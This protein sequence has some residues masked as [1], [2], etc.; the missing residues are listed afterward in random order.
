MNE[1]T[2]SKDEFGSSF[3]CNRCGKDQ[4]YVDK[5]VDCDHKPSKNETDM[6]QGK[7][8]IEQGTQ[9]EKTYCPYCRLELKGSLHKNTLQAWEVFNCEYD[10]TKNRKLPLQGEQY[11]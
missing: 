6:F 1:F 9:P 3:C 2:E 10:S 5:P 11:E 4:F 8:L 7:H